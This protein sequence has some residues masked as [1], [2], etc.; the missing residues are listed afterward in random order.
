MMKALSRRHSS[1]SSQ[2]RSRVDSIFFSTDL[3][4]FTRL[5]VAWDEAA[6]VV[7]GGEPRRLRT[8]DSP[9]DTII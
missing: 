8:A 4:V 9:L 1:R 5:L 6:L 2:A 3:T 7:V